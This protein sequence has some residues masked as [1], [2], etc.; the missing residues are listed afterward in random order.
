[1]STR[2]LTVLGIS[3]CI[4]WGI[5]YY[6]FAV[7]LLP[8][9][10]ELGIEPWVGTGAFSLALFI[11]AA[12][13]PRIGRWAD[14]GHGGHV[15]QI[16]GFAGAAL[17]T[18]WTVVPTV[19]TL[20]AVWALLGL[21]MSM[22]LYEPAFAIVARAHG[23][24]AQRLRALATIT[25]FGGL[26]ST[27]ALPA[28]AWLVERLGWKSSV[29][30][31]ALTL[32]LSTYATR[33]LVLTELQ[34]MAADTTGATGAGEATQPRPHL[35][36]MTLVFALASLGSAALMSNL[37][38]AL[39]ERRVSPALAASLGGLLGLMQVPGRALLMRGA[40][41]ASPT[42]L[43]L[44]CLLLQGVGLL[45][46]ATV[47]SVTLLATSIA[48]FAVG[49]GLATLARPHLVQSLYGLEQAGAL[50]GR[51]ARAQQ[52]AR[53]AGPVVAATL[54]ARTSYAVAFMAI[55]ALFAGAS[56]AWAVMLRA[57]R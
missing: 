53:A 55:S 10:R 46:I 17:L 18:I 50:N 38:P 27:A 39:G 37:V 1:M 49:S 4:N 6:A 51:L 23:D 15:L 47:S 52:L 36:L 56:V 12:A 48:V 19:T 42:R 26:A 25:V 28:T 31:L 7:L 35:G 3:Q 5:L 13:A 54:A 43:V 32:A 57:S 21:C 22:T 40:F 11:S 44:G 16:G 29:I 24:R 34:P 8:V 41:V 33:R 45:A 30:V 9:S 20:Y 14:L 2:A